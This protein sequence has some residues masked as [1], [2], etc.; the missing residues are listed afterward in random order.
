MR[1]MV[2]SVA[3]LSLLGALLRPAAEPGIHEAARKGELDRVRHLLAGDRKL[4]DARD[5]QRRTPL[6][7]A[8]LAR[9]WPVATFLIESGAD[10][11]AQDGEGMTALLA[12]AFFGETPLVKLI[13]A[14]GGDAAVDAHV[15]AFTPLHLGAR[16]GHKEITELLLARG[17]PLEARDREGRT[18]LALAAAEGQSAV[19]ETLLAR[20]ASIE[21]ADP[22]GSTP[23]LLA[24]LSGQPAAVKTLLSKGARVNA[25]NSLGSTPLSVAI[26]DGHAEVAD[27]LR[28]AGAHAVT[29]T[30]SAPE[31]DYLGQKRPGLTAELFAPGL[32]ST[33]G[34]ELNSVFTPDGRE[35]YFTVGR[36]SPRRWAIKVMRRT[37]NRWGAPQVA[38]FSGTYS[39]VDLFISHDGKQ[40]LYCSNRPLSGTGEPKKDFDIWVVERAGDGWSQPRNLGGAV[41]TEAQEFYPSLTRAGVLFF[42]SIRPEGRGAG[43][44]YFSRREEGGYP[45]VGNAGGMINTEGFESDP[46]VAPDGDYVI[47]SANRKGGFGQGDLNI[48]FRA[49]DGSWTP[50]RNL[51]SRVNTSYHENCAMVTPDGKYLF[52]TRA[53]DIYW[54]DA[55]II[56]ARHSRNQT[57]GAALQSRR[58]TPRSARH[59]PEGRY[60][61]VDARPTE[62]SQAAPVSTVSST[63]YREMR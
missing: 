7:E 17:A 28:A 16:G 40:L 10:V 54:V 43:D 58:P 52:F 13:L 6:L 5:L 50:P 22:R 14:H 47:F 38:S 60:A 18:P 49:K 23:L 15:L 3:L 45:R 56:I 12:S 4:L 53:G 26:R 62:C 25:R 30:P 31:G 63:E 27:A 61:G 51:G 8:V 33:E 32:I 55:R 57:G 29:I 35:F 21:A 48:T 9:Q 44:I 2:R 42:Q 1:H 36:G 46:F 37:G 20:G 11:N 59:R 34:E 39:D 41:N 19:L 24:A